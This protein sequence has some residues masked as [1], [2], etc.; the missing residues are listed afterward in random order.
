LERK[1]FPYRPKPKHWKERSFPIDQNLLGDIDDGRVWQEFM[2][3]DG[4]P[5]LSGNHN[6]C[7]SINEDW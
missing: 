6:F 7:F 1:K 5:F 3:I 4:I 2:N